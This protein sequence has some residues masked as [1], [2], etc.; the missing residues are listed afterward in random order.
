MS[1]LSRPVPAADLIAFVAVL[2]TGVILV[3]GGVPPESLGLVAMSM[4]ALY[5]SFRAA[6][7][8][9]RARS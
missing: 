7:A 2:V 6:P 4:A 1:R 8:R 5:G 9:M 3:A